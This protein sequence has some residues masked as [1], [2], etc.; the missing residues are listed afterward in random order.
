MGKRKTIQRIILILMALIVVAATVA[1]FILQADKPW[2]AFYI[3]CCGGVLAVNLVIML[4][5]VRKNVK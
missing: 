5:F 3:A 4:I 1:Y 2:M